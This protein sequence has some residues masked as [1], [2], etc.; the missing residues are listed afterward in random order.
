M[1]SRTFLAVCIALAIPASIVFAEA[2]DSMVGFA[3]EKPAPPEPPKEEK[4]E[5]VAAGGS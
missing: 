2:P 4:P 3:K 1:R 5:P